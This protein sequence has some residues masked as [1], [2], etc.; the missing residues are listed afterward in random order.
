MR[1]AT[2]REILISI[3]SDV[4]KDWSG[5]RPR[6]DWTGISDAEIAAD[7]EKLSEWVGE[8][9]ARERAEI[10]AE[11]DFDRLYGESE[12]RWAAFTSTET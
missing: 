11:A 8:D 1:T 9:I 3:H 6:R 7:T 4:Y 2:D 10:E 5:I 12:S